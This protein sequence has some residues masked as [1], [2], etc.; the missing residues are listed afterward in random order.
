MVKISVSLNVQMDEIAIQDDNIFEQN[1]FNKSYIEIHKD[2]T[3]FLENITL[4]AFYKTL[5]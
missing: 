4:E 3:V 5:K 1:N 2:C